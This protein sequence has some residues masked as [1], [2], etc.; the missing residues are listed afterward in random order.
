[1][2]NE[3]DLNQGPIPAETI[4]D[5][6]GEAINIPSVAL[7]RPTQ[8]IVLNEIESLFK[9]S[10]IVPHHPLAKQALAAI[11]V[12]GDLDGAEDKD[13][14][15]FDCETASQKIILAANANGLGA[16]ISSIYPD[17]DRI[18]EMTVLLG[19]PDNIIAH[20][21]VAMGSPARNISD[22]EDVNN[23]RIHYNGFELK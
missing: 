2:Q 17:R 20:S 6:I 3:V 4:I 11:V 14:W 22:I 7:G 13:K 8:F 15:M 1:M 12:C 5:L 9:A 16:H 19:L 10:E 21:Y 23:G 18:Y